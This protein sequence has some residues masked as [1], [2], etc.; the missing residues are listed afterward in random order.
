VSGA[1]AGIGNDGAQVADFVKHRTE[2]KQAPP[3]TLER[4]VRERAAIVSSD[5][6]ENTDGPS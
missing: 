1:G 4:T 3:D 5:P 2:A 6:T